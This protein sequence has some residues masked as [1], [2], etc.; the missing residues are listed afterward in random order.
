[1]N[2][3]DAALKEKEDA[4]VHKQTQLAKALDAAAALQYEVARL[5]QASKVRELEALESAHETDSDFCRETSFVL[6]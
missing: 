3:K 4:L 2:L 6:S 1:M 5:T